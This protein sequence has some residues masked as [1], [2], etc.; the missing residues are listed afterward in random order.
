[1]PCVHADIIDAERHAAAHRHTPAA[2]AATP[3]DYFA[4]AVSFARC[5][6]PM[7]P[8][9]DYAADYFIFSHA[10]AAAIIR[11]R[12]AAILPIFLRLFSLPMMPPLFSYFRR[13]LISLPPRR[14]ER[15]YATPCAMPLPA[16]HY[17]LLMPLRAR[18]ARR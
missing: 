4:A 13:C 9:S 11:T 16:R 1:M 8:I 3:P 18:D 7:T 10:A 6:T 17:T 12:H 5:A 15:H 2:I 14:H